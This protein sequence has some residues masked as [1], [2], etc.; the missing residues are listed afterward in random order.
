MG[1]GGLR[2]RSF[3]ASWASK[4]FL[5]AFIFLFPESSQFIAFFR[6]SLCRRKMMRRIFCSSQN[7]ALSPKMGRF[8]LAQASL[9]SPDWLDSAYGGQYMEIIGCLACSECHFETA[10][11]RT[12]FQLG[13]Q[14][15]NRVIHDEQAGLEARSPARWMAY[16]GC[17]IPLA[18]NYGARQAGCAI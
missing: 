17:T 6:V 8:S 7:E 13:Q 14:L 11:D 9:P 3:N 12:V 15:S 4:P 1:S 18:P 2:T 16:P 10:A 5:K